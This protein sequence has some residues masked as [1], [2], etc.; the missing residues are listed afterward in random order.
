MTHPNKDVRQEWVCKIDELLGLEGSLTR[1]LHEV[2]ASE[3]HA[4]QL[5]SVNAR[6]SDGRTAS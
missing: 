6:P 3:E 5:V 2:L 1:T 4:V